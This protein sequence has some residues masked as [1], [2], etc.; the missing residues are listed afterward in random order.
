MELAELA[1]VIAVM[2]VMGIVAS[3]GTRYWL[4]PWLWRRRLRHLVPPQGT[5]PDL[6]LTCDGITYDVTSVLLDA[7]VQ[8]NGRQLWVLPGPEHVRLDRAGPDH[9]F[10]LGMKILPARTDIEVPVTVS[11]DGTT[12]RFMTMTE[13]RQKYPGIE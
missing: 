4:R 6:Q 10:W 5:R 12:V 1:Q 3:I 2:V 11:D 13:I 7:G 8:D 9:G